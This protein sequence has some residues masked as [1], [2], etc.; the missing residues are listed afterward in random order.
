MLQVQ[1]LNSF[2]FCAGLNFSS[3][4]AETCALEHGLV[5]CNNHNMTCH[6]QSYCGFP[7][8]SFPTFNR[9]SYLLLRSLWNV[10]SP[11]MLVSLKMSM[12]ITLQK[13][14]LSTSMVPST[15]TLPSPK[16]LHPLPQMETSYFPLLSQLSSS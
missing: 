16:P 14:D 12:L 7:I 13:L 6:F 3:F 1:Y 8:G 10:W 9:P 4:T 5:W 2:S 11:V 15:P